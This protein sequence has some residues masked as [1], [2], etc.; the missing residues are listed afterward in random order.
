MSNA[1]QALAIRLQQI[2]MDSLDE[3][4]G[5]LASRQALPTISTC[6]DLLAERY[7]ARG[8]GCCVSCDALTSERW[9]GAPMCAD[10]M[11]SSPAIEQMRL[12]DRGKQR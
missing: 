5:V 10:C 4:L 2:L 12:Y 7:H 9:E 1:Q 11:A 6:A 3:H 8:L